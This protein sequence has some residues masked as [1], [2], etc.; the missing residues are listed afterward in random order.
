VRDG[1]LTGGLVTGGLV[2]GGLVTGG[3]V[4]GGLVTGG[5]VTGGLVT[6][7]LVTGGLV[8]GGRTFVVV[9]LVDAVGVVEGEDVRTTA[10]TITMIRPARPPTAA[11][12]FPFRAVGR[13][14]A[15]QGLF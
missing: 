9:G 3:L 6:G 4:V 10:M 11:S 2:T 14:G 15:C 7:G 8:T 5:L 1:V 13:G 12:S